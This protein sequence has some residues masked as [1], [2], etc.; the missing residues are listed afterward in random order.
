LPKGSLLKNNVI[1][2]RYP[3]C[4]IVPVGGFHRKTN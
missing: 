3:F 1:L 2:N 4:P